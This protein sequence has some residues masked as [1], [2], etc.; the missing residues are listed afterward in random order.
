M[1]DGLNDLIN[2]VLDRACFPLLILTAVLA[3]AGYLI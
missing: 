1:I 2:L 3:V